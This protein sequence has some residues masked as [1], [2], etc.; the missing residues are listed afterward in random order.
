MTPLTAGPFG[1]PRTTY[2][3]TDLGY[4]SV[5]SQRHKTGMGG[6]DKGHTKAAEPSS[7]VNWSR[8]GSDPHKENC[9]ARRGGGRGGGS[10]VN[11]GI[12]WT[13][14]D[15]RTFLRKIR[16]KNK[17]SS[18]APIFGQNVPSAPS[19]PK[20]FFPCELPVL[21][22]NHLPLQKKSFPFFL[23]TPGITTLLRPPC[24]EI[25]KSQKAR[26]QLDGPFSTFR[27]IFGPFSNLAP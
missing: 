15:I 6:R 12:F 9:F 8:T 14:I 26:F 21:H 10:Y 1:S 27:C 23:V 3:T 18:A 24:E 16:Q 11:Q 22:S 4:G 7:G 20:A 2:L 19:P 25:V 13:K 17:F 5:L